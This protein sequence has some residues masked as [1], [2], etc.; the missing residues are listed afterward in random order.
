MTKRLQKEFEAIQKSNIEVKAILPTNDLKLWHIEFL[1]AKSTIY[2]GEHFK[3]QFRF[4]NDYVNLRL[5]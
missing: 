5:G 3:L 1:G 4:N 2:E